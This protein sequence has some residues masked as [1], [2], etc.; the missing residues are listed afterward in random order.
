[1]FYMKNYINID[2]NAPY[3]YYNKIFKKHKKNK[4]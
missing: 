4:K 1:M 3:N 2:Y